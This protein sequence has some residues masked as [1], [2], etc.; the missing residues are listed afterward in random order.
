MFTYFRD[1]TLDDIELSY[2]SLSNADFTEATVL[3]SSLEGADSS[4]AVFRRAALKEANLASSDLSNA[5]FTE[6][7]LVGASFAQAN[8]TG[9]TFRRTRLDRVDFSNSTIG[10]TLLSEL[11][12][13]GVRGLETVRHISPSSVGID[14]F[15]QSRGRIPSIFLRGAGVSE[16]FIE[17]SGSLAGSGVEHYSCFISYSGSDHEFANR[18]HSDLTAL[19]IR[20]WFAPHD[21]VAGRRLDEQIDQAIRISDL[22]ILILSPS[23]L[24]SSWVKTEIAKVRRRE[25]QER[26]HLLFPISILPFE[27]LKHWE[28]IDSD[29]G[30]D[31][32]REIREYFIPDFS[33]WKNFDAYSRSLLLLTKDLS[34][35]LAA[36]KERMG[37]GEAR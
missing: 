34:L 27:E 12:L 4:D 11:D 18:L 26:R 28:L 14:T 9:A 8:L 1:T 15:L 7:D 24:H 25:V 5:D 33:N 22:V 37:S 16:L 19:G 20:C 30:L 23:S 2:S 3:A 35:R 10:G 31:L 32:A 21:L 36:P 6:A 17:Y 13:S 29:A